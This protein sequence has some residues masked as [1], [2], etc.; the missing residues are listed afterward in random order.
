MG[1]CILSVLTYGSQ[2]RTPMKKE[3]CKLQICKMKMERKLPNINGDIHRTTKIEDVA[4]LAAY[5]SGAG[6]SCDQDDGDAC[7]GQ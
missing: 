2:K 1:M 3:L 5:P 7:S 4:A 6:T